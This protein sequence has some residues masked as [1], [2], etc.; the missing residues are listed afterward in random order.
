MKKSL[1]EEME[2][3]VDRVMKYEGYVKFMENKEE[4]IDRK[5]EVIE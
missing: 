3:G 1:F 5:S 4:R 2:V